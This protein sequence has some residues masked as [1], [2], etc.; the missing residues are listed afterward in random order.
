VALGGPSRLQ[1]VRRHLFRAIDKVLDKP[2]PGETHRNE[3]V[4]LKKLR[5]GDGSWSTR[6]EILGWIIDSVRQTIE[7]PPHQKQVLASIFTELAGCK[8]VS[9]KSWQRYL[10]QL[11]FVSTAIPG[12]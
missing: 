11:R 9:N 4:S 1:K 2:L 12:C 7:L 8:R 5:K 3:A 10:G 6:K